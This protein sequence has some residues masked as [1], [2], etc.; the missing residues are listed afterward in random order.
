MAASTSAGELATMKVALFAIG[1]ILFKCCLE[2]LGFEREWT[3]LAGVAGHLEGRRVKT[4]LLPGC[5]L[6]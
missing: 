1:G 6:S 5:A 3:R 4:K 2:E